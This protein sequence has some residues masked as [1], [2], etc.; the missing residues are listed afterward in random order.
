MTEHKKPS[1]TSGFVET[2]ATGSHFIPTSFPATKA[3]QERW[4]VDAVLRQSRAESRDLWQLVAP[5]EQN[6]ESDL[7]F[8][9]CT[10]RGTEYLELM[11]VAPIEDVEGAYSKARGSYQHGELADWIQS[12]IGAKRSRYGAVK[13]K[14]HLLLYGTD[15][16][17]PVTE[18]VLTLLS[19][20]SLQANHGFASI[21][22]FFPD[23]EV[24]GRLTLIH[25]RDA[26]DFAS[27]DEVK[28]R[29]RQSCFGDLT[30]VQSTAKGSFIVPIS[31]P[32][33][34]PR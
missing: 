27:F 32:K 17:F 30:K 10:V 34:P 12:K 33:Y 11:E 28:R 3:A 14:I 4:M 24:E 18:N 16:H 29:G 1:G 23:D 31:A 15:W 2:D 21:Y 19:F 22:Y 26:S 6:G 25:P 9:L 13:S 5:P 20:W 7:D 8:T